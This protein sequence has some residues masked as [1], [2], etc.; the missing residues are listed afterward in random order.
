MANTQHIINFIREVGLQVHERSLSDATFLPGILI[1][2][3]ELVVDLEKL[4][5]PG[6][7]LHEAGHISITAPSERDSLGG[8][9]KSGPGEEMAAIAWSYDAAAIH[10]GIDASEV[11]HEEGYKGAGE[12][13]VEN[14]EK[15]GWVGVPLLEWYGMTRYQREDLNGPDFPKMHEWVRKTENPSA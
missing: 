8:D 3:G 13:L 2:R 15:G 9:L 5:H 14:F 12:S 11:F 1:E 6:D 7:M 4:D 10:L